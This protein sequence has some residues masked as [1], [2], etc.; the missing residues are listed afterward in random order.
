MRLAS[1]SDD[2]TARIWDIGRLLDDSTE[3]IT[4]L[5]PSEI[6]ILTGHKDSIGAIG[7][8]PNR[9]KDAHELLAT[10]AFFLTSQLDL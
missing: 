2:N 6:M 3:K 10:Y 1:C 7:W 8:C 4:A 9:P 5:K